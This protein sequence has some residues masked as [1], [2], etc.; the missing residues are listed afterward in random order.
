MDLEK[1]LEKTWKPVYIVPL[2][3]LTIVVAFFDGLGFQ[4][5]QTVADPGLIYQQ[6]VEKYM[7][8]FH[9]LIYTF[10]AGSTLLVLIYKDL[11]NA[12]AFLV[13]TLSVLWSGL[14]DLIYYQLPFTPGMPETLTHLNGTPVGT[15]ATLLNNGVVTP[16]M[17]YLN[18]IF[19]LTIGF[20]VSGYIRYGKELSFL[21]R[22]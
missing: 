6:M 5:F 16:E 11:D 18:I 12:L 13:F 22:L 15:T 19:F 8:L 17:L 10:V 14:W 20:L 9:G 7:Q 3:V 4:M 21:D 2:I 1:L